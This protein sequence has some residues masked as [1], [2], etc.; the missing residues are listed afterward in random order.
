[1]DNLGIP[2][3]AG[4]FT[5]EEAGTV[6]YGV[7]DSVDLLK[8]Y[9]FV[10]ARL[11]SI[12]AAHLAHTP[13]WEVK[14]AFSYHMWLVAEHSTALRKRVA[15]MREPPLHLD[16]APSADLAACF[17]EVIRARST[18][19]LLVGIYRVVIPELARALRKHL[20]ETNPL[21]DQPTC[22]IL[23]FTLQEQDEMIAW[24]HQAI[25]ALT[26]DAE[27]AR[28]AEAWA[29][30]V[31]AFLQAA[32]GIPG[33][34][35]VPGG[36]PAPEPRA[37]GHPYT[38]DALPQRDA[39]FIDPFN[40][41]A[42]IDSYF[43]DESR[44]Y[45]ERVYALYYKRLREIDVPEWMAPIIY[46][47]RG[48]PWEYYHDLS[49]QLWDEARHAMMG[50]VGLYHEGMPFYQYPVDIKSSVSLNSE[51]EPLEAHIIL[52]GIEQSLMPRETGKHYELV[53]AQESGHPLAVMFQDYD[54]AD[55][56][57]HA[58]I[59]RKWLVPELSSMEQLRATIAPLT[60]RWEDVRDRMKGLSSQ[61]PWW[62]GFLEEIRRRR[63]LI[64]LAEQSAD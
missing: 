44:D 26:Q 9:I 45:D 51:F 49:R 47:T 5:Y 39:R 56:V 38:M 61:E 57:L 13:E 27:N 43:S 6:G 53:V 50:E 4:L 3:L 23:K 24:G 35:S 34:L 20:A 58:Q 42:M 21:V 48:K 18:T 40:Q 63:E 59:G 12:Y 10:T 30:H 15:E 46:K 29:R 54:W 14:C 25:A 60:A 37:D 32:G 17:D 8:R 1:M 33:D 16:K 52:W 22:R 41:S 31:Q 19:E 64:D 7:Q 36:L 28:V 62:P 11:N 55:E 2:P